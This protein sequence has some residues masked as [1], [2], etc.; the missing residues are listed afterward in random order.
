MGIRIVRTEKGFTGTVTPP[1][2]R[3]AVSIVDPVSEWEL[4]AILAAHGVDDVRERITIIDG[5]KRTFSRGLNARVAEIWQI[6]DRLQFGT[7]T[8]ADVEVVTRALADPNDSIDKAW[9]TSIVDDIGANP[10]TLHALHTLAN[11]SSDKNGLETTLNL[12]AEWEPAEVVAVLGRRFTWPSHEPQSAMYALVR[13][14]ERAI[15]RRT[16]GAD[17]TSRL[18][19]VMTAIALDATADETLRKVCARTLSYLAG[20]SDEDRW[21]MVTELDLRM[22]EMAASRSARLHGASGRA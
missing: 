20:L 7:V 14:A 3:E 1:F 18:L 5:A 15:R 22:I 17:V 12:I 2:V 9:L 13:A 4:D 21:K 11:S 10:V 16:G 6:I 19:D 8:D